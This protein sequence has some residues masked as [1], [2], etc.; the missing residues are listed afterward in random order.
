MGKQLVNF[1]TCGCESST[2]FLSFT[3]AIKPRSLPELLLRYQRDFRYLF[4]IINLNNI[5]VLQILFW[6]EYNIKFVFPP[7][8]SFTTHILCLPSM[9]NVL[10]IFYWFPS[11]LNLTTY[12]SRWNDMK[13]IIFVVVI[14]LYL[15]VLLKTCNISL[16]ICQTL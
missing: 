1:I 14:I 7:S 11:K 5:F 13:Y 2:P 9:Y 10:L 8:L 6:D 15:L 4:S 12:Q 16:M 3:K